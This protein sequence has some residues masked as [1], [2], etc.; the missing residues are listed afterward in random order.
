MSNEIAPDSSANRRVPMVSLALAACM[1]FCV[2]GCSLFVEAGTMILGRP[3][4]PAAFD[5]ATRKTL[6]GKDVKT[7]VI[8]EA[9]MGTDA[10]TAALDQ[11][12][13]AEVSRRLRQQDIGVVRSHKVA[14]WIDDKGGDWGSPEEL[15]EKFPEANFL[16]LLSVE[17]FSYLEKNSPGLYRGRCHLAVSVYENNEYNSKIYTRAIDSVYPKSNAQMADQL[18]HSAFRK[19]Y[20]DHLSMQ[21]AR[22][23][24]DHRPEETF[25]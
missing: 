13:Q 11:E 12:L 14:S 16:V 22:L 3:K 4:I 19:R 5:D 6:N 1:L 18:T 8:C 17:D 10:E 23:F 20:L 24:Y 2:S 7:V 9:P 25:H 21:I 15:F